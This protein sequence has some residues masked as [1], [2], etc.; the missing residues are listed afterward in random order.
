LNSSF[1][2]IEDSEIDNTLNESL[3]PTESEELE[4]GDEGVLYEPGQEDEDGEDADDFES[5]SDVQGLI[6]DPC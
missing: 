4:I 6:E 3:G 2:S 1:L 5:S